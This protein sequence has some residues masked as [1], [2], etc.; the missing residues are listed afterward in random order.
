MPLT[1][2]LAED[3]ALV[4]EAIEGEYRFLKPISAMHLPP[5]K[6]VIHVF[7]SDFR[8]SHEANTHIAALRGLKPGEDWQT[9]QLHW[10]GGA[11]RIAPGSPTNRGMPFADVVF[12]KEI[13][14]APVVTGIFDL[15]L[16]AHFPCGKARLAGMRIKDIWRDLARARERLLELE[17]HFNVGTYLHVDYGEASPEKAMKTYYDCPKAYRRW[18]GIQAA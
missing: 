7:C 1:A 10:H 3:F 12:L 8:R 4:R 2:E 15:V 17:P 13:L 16:A 9:H 6:P 14:D 11:L 5:R 18:R